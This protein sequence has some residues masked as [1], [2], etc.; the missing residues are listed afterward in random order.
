MQRRSEGHIEVLNGLSNPVEFCEKY[1][2]L[3]APSPRLR[4]AS[5]KT[6]KALF[7][8]D[9]CVSNKYLHMK[10]KTINYFGIHLGIYVVVSYHL[11]ESE[12]SPFRHAHI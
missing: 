7:I 2:K 4:H 9:F 10:V 12:K 11:L 1:V 5:S 8:K 3:P 6:W